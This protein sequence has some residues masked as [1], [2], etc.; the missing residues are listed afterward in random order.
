MGIFLTVPPDR[1]E[2]TSVFATWDTAHLVET[3]R[4]DNAKTVLLAHIVSTAS[5]SDVVFDKDMEV[6]TDWK[7]AK[8]KKSNKGHVPD[9][10]TVCLHSL[11]VSPKL[12][13]CELGK[14]IMKSFLQHVRSIGYQRV[15]LICQDVRSNPR[16]PIFRLEE[17]LLTLQKPVPRGLL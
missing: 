6:P 2:D 13:G 14:L 15:A 12:Q 10:R 3:G 5:A 17:P 16:N 7:T 8:G 1:V 9:G 11:A 4:L